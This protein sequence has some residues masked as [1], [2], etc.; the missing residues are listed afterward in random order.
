MYGGSLGFIERAFCF[1]RKLANGTYTVKVSGKYVVTR[2]AG[3]TVNGAD[4][5]EMIRV[6]Q[7]GTVSGVV[8]SGTAK[9]EKAAVTGSY[10]VKALVDGYEVG[11]QTVTIAAGDTEKDNVNFV[12]SVR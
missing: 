11:M 8:Y 10:T 6:E 3:V 9:V 2:E 7:A 1:S 4:A 5:A 12:L